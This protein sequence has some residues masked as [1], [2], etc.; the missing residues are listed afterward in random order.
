MRY[1]GTTTFAGLLGP[2]FRRRRSGA[3]ISNIGR[4]ALHRYRRL[5]PPYASAQQRF[6]ARN[7]CETYCKTALDFAH[8]R[9]KVEVFGKD[10]WV[11]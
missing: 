2:W 1:G 11:F 7:L 10:V 4:G 8:H 5:W 9:C 3:F 6:G